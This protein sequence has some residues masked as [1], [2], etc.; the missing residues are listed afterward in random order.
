MASRPYFVSQNLRK[1]FKM[2]AALRFG[3]KPLLLSH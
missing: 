1:D 2:Q 3:S